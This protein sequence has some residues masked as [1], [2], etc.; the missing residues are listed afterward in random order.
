MQ[1]LWLFNWQHCLENVQIRSFFWSLFSP[2]AGKIRTRK[3]SVF[4]RFSRSASVIVPTNKILWSK[5]VCLFSIL[6]TPVGRIF[7]SILLTVNRRVAS[8]F[9]IHKCTGQMRYSNDFLKSL[10]SPDF[11]LNEFRALKMLPLTS[12]FFYFLIFEFIQVEN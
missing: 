9:E 3:N 7:I 5:Q 1:L 4:G 2:T 6:E 11:K 8:A 10:T 12:T